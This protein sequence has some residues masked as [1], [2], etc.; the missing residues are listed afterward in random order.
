VAITGDD[1]LCA[2]W[3][4]YKHLDTDTYGTVR[5]T[6]TYTYNSIS[7]SGNVS[8][9]HDHVVEVPYVYH[10]PES[11]TYTFLS[12][13]VSLSQFDP[14]LGILNSVE[15]KVESDI[16]VETH[17][18]YYWDHAHAS[19]WWYSNVT[20]SVN[21]LQA[22]FSQDHN[23]HTIGEGYHNY[24][25]TID[26][27]ASASAPSGLADFVGTGMV[28]VEITGDDKLCAW[29]NAYKHI[30]TDTYGTV[31]VTL[32]YDF[33]PVKIDIKPDTLDLSSKDKWVTCYIE[34]PEAYDVMDIDGSTVMLDGI[35]AHIGEEGWARA[36]ANSSNIM[37]QDGDAIPERMVK[38]YRSEVQAIVEIPE[39]LITVTGQ[40]TDG[41][42]FGGRDVIRVIDEKKKE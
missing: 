14:G 39:A 7:F 1:K 35:P 18:Y 8:F 29:W 19:L 12:D 20:A 33:T 17:Y 22:T 38:F 2:W 41:C 11:L 15:L 37:D 25:F 10:C 5:V 3:N 27:T 30:D 6:L 21:G 13:T 9:D 36:E 23:K 34:L 28:D 40:L 16:D 24:A 42:S 32:T 31:A 26:G 4:S